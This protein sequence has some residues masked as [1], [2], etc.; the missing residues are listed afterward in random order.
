[1]VQKLS[2]A[3]DAELSKEQITQR[4]TVVSLAGALIHMSSKA[5]V[6]KL[7]DAVRVN[8]AELA[9]GKTLELFK[10]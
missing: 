9:V 10:S 6:A 7:E 1:M 3:R 8:S 2:K 4:N 5:N